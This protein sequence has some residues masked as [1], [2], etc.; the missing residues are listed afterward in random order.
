[1]LTTLKWKDGEQFNYKVP[2]PP[3]YDINAAT[4][5][6]IQISGS[7]TSIRSGPTLQASNKCCNYQGAACLAKALL[8]AVF[9]LP[10]LSKRFKV[11]EP[12]E[13]VVSDGK[14]GFR[15]VQ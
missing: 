6:N 14:L 12:P 10:T 9:R 13:E 3:T 1:M 5:I 2:V 11:S 15:E 7:P 8:L 4:N